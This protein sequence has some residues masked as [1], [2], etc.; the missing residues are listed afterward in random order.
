[1]IIFFVA[2]S[3]PNTNVFIVTFSVCGRCSF[4]NIVTKW[5]PE[6]EHH[7]PNSHILLVGT[8]IDLRDDIEMIE[9]LERKGETM[10]SYEEAEKFAHDLGLKI[11]FFI[12]KFYFI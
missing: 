5:L 3:Y 6:L 12:F 11:I 10:I 8:K 2:H 1:M 9:K 4:Q 7:M